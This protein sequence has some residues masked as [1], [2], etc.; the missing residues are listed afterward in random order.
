MP[1]LLEPA[2]GAQRPVPDLRAVLLGVSAWA[3]GLAVFGLPGWT[4]LVL[5][6][7]GG[8]HRRGPP[9]SGPAGRHR[10]GVPAGRVGGRRGGGAAGR[11][12]PRQPG[13]RA[14]PRRRGGHGDARGS[15]SDPVVRTGRFGTYALT[16]VSVAEVTGRGVVHRTR[17]PVLV[18][19][20]EGWAG[21]E[22]GSRRHGDRCAGSRAGAGPGRRAL[23]R[24]RPH[25]G[26]GPRGAARRGGAGA[27]GHPELGGVVVPG[28]PGAG[29]GARG[30]RR[31]ADVRRRGR[32][33]PDL[34]A[35]P[36][37]GGVGHQPHAGGRLPGRAGPVGRGPGPRAD[38]RGRARGGR[39]RAAGPPGAERAAGGRDGLGRAGR[40]GRPRPGHAG[41]GRWASRCSCCC[42][43]TRGWCSRSGSCSRRSRRPG[44]CSSARPSAT[45]CSPGCRGGPPRRSPYPFAAQL[46]CTPVVA[47]ISGQVSLVAVVA[48]L[49]VAAVVGPATVLGLLGGVR[50]PWRCRRSAGWWAG[51]PACAPAGS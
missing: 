13:G 30:R 12:Q 10:A 25:D 3:G 35:D 43:S 27:R 44:S 36:P 38:R 40:D 7:L 34:R 6:A 33:L 1:S 41:S 19:G 42:C 16:R 48:N 47:A 23:H 5:V 32:G 24:A 46:A 37:R 9:S 14:G 15:S 4:C 50:D 26:G 20:D 49:V 2:D 45:R 21:V 29:A 11:R 8:G 22:L 28:R 39:V 18:I 51:R 31:P 17:V